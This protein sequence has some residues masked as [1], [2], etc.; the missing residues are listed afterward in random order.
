[1]TVTGYESYW[2]DIV[3]DYPGRERKIDDWD[4]ATGNIRGGLTFGYDGSYKPY[5]VITIDRQPR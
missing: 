1:M 2:K 3:M 5:T 4:L